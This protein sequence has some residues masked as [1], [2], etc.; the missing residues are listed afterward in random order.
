MQDQSIPVHKLILLFIADQAPGIR[1]SRLGDAALASLSM[2]YFD[3]AK[4]LDELIEAGLIELET[5]GD[6]EIERCRLTD[7]GRSALAILQEQIP[8][9]TRRFLTTYLDDTHLQRAAADQITASFQPAEEGGSRLTCSLREG[10]SESLSLSLILPSEA[11]AR[12]AAARW[13]EDAPAVFSA[14]LQ[15]LLAEEDQKE[16]P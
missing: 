14:L 13:R 2:D 1:R 5:G 9:S 4:T 15:A 7:Q 16:K 8:L 6:Q 11:L 12:R 3:L 10:D